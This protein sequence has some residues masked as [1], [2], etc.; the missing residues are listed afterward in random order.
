MSVS[1]ADDFALGWDVESGKNLGPKEFDGPVMSL[2]F[3]PVEEGLVAVG[4]WDNRVHLLSSIA[5]PPSL[6][7]HKGSVWSI[8]FSPDGKRLA[9]GSQDGSVILW[10]IS[11]RL[12]G[13][14]GYVRGVSFSADSR[15]LASAG[16]DKQ[17]LLWDADGRRQSA[18]PLKDRDEN[19]T[20]VAFSPDG[21]LL[22]AGEG[23]G[24]VGLWE[25]GTWAKLDYAPRL[26]GEAVMS[27]AFSSDG[28]LVAAGG[29]NGTVA[30]WDVRSRRM[31]P[32]PK[33][34]EDAV[35]KV[36]FSSTGLL[37]SSD[38][39][40]A[41]VLWDVAGRKKLA[42]VEQPLT[43]EIQSLAFSP[44]GRLLA[45]GCHG[46]TIYFWDVTARSARLLR[47]VV[48]EQ[49]GPVTSLAFTTDGKTLAS[50]SVDGTVAFWDVGSYRELG[51]A[52]TRHGGMVWGLAF[53][54]DGKLMATGSSDKTVFLWDGDFDPTALSGRAR[55]VANRPLD[56]QERS[57]YLERPSL[58][59]PP[60]SRRTHG[61]PTGGRDRP[62]VGSSI[63]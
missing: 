11:P 28:G 24:T 51:R 25:A 45:G 49:Q 33:E 14:T 5:A 3:S 47:A 1:G 44:D 62:G 40:G 30:M 56:E 15:T 4:G 20:S 10:D 9:S 53:S 13:H 43:G 55:R 16:E 12:V 59:P 22:A 58:L 50:G 63:K 29:L 23:D 19:F 2:A 32:L 46:R 26:D 39:K 8:A 48:T 36:A 57:Q 31:L 6:R 21:R 52:A 61:R 54:P 42:R 18:P 35:W 37:A 60:E 34:H 38:R 27:V 7:G 41:V 17:L